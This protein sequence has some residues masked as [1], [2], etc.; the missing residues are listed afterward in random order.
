ME[1]KNEYQH[2]VGKI[3]LCWGISNRVVIGLSFFKGNELDKTVIDRDIVERTL[4]TF[5]PKVSIEFLEF[6]LKAM[7][8]GE[9]TRDHWNK[10]M[11]SY[12]NGLIRVSKTYTYAANVEKEQMFEGMLSAYTGK[13]FRK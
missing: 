13:I 4:K 10:Y 3:F 7:E 6:T 5:L 2:Q 12:W 8:S 1:K 11:R 9:L